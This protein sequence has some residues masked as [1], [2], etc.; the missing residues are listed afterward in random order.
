[1]L[2]AIHRLSQ[3]AFIV[4]CLVKAQGKLYLFTFLRLR[5]PTREDGSILIIR[6][7]CGL[8]M[9]KYGSQSTLPDCV[10]QIVPLYLCDPTLPPGEGSRMTAASVSVGQ[11]KIWA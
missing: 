9:R 6:V 10:A 7:V 11:A 2:G 5:Y 4:W 8:I 3:Y 1:M